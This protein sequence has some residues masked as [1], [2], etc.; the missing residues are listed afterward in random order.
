MSNNSNEFVIKLMALLDEQKSKTQINSDIKD[1]EKLVRKLK[2]TAILAKG[3]T[4]TELNQTIKQ[5]ESQLR[6]IKL[7]ARN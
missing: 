1:L 2:L 3:T 7:Q 5:L 6:Q 4:K